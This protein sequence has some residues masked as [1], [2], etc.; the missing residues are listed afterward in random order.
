MRER[1]RNDLVPLSNFLFLFF[2]LIVAWHSSDTSDMATSV[3]MD[4]RYKL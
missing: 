4:S 2:K 3:G 1:E